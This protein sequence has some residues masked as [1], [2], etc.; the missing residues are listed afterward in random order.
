[1]IIFPKKV[2]ELFW[3]GKCDVIAG[4]LRKSFFEFLVPNLVALGGTGGANFSFARVWNDFGNMWVY[5]TLVFSVTNLFWVSTAYHQTYYFLVVCEYCMGMTK[6]LPK[7]TK[8]LL[9]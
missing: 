5:R 2:S 3:D 9:G 8:Y 1:L 7:A 4:G 6:T